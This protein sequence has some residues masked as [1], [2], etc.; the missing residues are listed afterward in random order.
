MRNLLVAA[1]GPLQAST[2]E[3]AE[4]LAG[5]ASDLDASEAVFD[6]AEVF[7]LPTESGSEK[8]RKKSGK[9]RKKSWEAPHVRASRGWGCEADNA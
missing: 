4:I 9:K 6:D 1:E 2:A 7:S 5:D 8:K 3:A